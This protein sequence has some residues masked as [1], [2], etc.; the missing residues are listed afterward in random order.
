VIESRWIPC[1]AV[2]AGLASGGESG[3]CVRRIIRLVKVRH[4]AADASGWSTY[5][6]APRV[7]GIA[8]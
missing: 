4:V 8:V 6:L 1:T 2:M 3:L 7:A 5:K